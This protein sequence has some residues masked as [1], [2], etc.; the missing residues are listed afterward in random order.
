[1][2][3]RGNM[4][5]LSIASRNMVPMVKD[6][7]VETAKQSGEKQSDL[8]LIARHKPGG[9]R[10][11]PKDCIIQMKSIKSGH[12]GDL[13]DDPNKKVN[14]A[15]KSE[16]HDMFPILKEFIDDFSED[17]KVSYMDIFLIIRIK[18]GEQADDLESLELKA[19]T[20]KGI[21]P[22]RSEIIV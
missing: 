19:Q 10:E 6:L 16:L 18:A 5:M 2:S 21:E 4:A 3:L 13:Q 22:M 15:Q 1:M 8:Y 7:F 17:W 11:N 9:D 14:E 12:V 20:R